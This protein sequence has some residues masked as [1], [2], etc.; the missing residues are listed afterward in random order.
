MIFRKL[1]QEVYVFDGPTG[2]KEDG[3]IIVW[4]SLTPSVRL[5]ENLFGRSQEWGARIDVS[6]HF[7]TV[8]VSPMVF[9]TVAR[10]FS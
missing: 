9:G 4:L 7:E 5:N 8:V 2:N 1:V 3:Y 10:V 6:E